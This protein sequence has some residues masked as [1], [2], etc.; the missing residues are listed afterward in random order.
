MTWDEI[1]GE[2]TPVTCAK[3]AKPATVGGLQGGL[4]SPYRIKDCDWAQPQSSPG[5]F[6]RTVNTQGNSTWLG[7]FVTSGVPAQLSGSLGF[8]FSPNLL[9]FESLHNQVSYP[10]KF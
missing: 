4:N 7:I 2:V 6:P 5:P 8:T 9:A 10:R 1:R 3:E